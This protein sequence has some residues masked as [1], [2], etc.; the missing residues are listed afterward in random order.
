MNVCVDA[1]HV[2]EPSKQTRECMRMQSGVSG[3][4]VLLFVAPMRCVAG[5]HSHI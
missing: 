4:T 5:V 1:Q 3:L 2:A